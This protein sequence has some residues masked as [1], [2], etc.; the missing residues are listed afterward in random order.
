M[1]LSKKKGQGIHTVQ[2]DTDD[3]EDLSEMFFIKMVSH[4]EDDII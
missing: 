4:D 1:C 2:E 3:N